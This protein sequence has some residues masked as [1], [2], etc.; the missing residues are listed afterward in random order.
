MPRLPKSFIAAIA[1]A[2]IATGCTSIP[3][4]AAQ[5]GA[6]TGKMAS[7]HQCMMMAKHGAVESQAGPM[8]CKMDC[9]CPMMQK[10]DAADAPSAPSLAPP[11]E[12]Q[13]TPDAPPAEH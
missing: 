10:H 7:D 5:D 8:A 9:N 3:T 11:E 1:G 12:H 4:H 2:L 6:M 13:H